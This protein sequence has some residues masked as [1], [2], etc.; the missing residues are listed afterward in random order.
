MREP[1]LFLACVIVTGQQVAPHGVI[2]AQIRVDLGDVVHALMASR[3]RFTS[4]P[5]R[6][7]SVSIIA[8]TKPIVFVQGNLPT[9]IHALPWL[10]PAAS[11][12]D[13]SMPTLT[14]IQLLSTNVCRT[15]LRSVEVNTS[16]QY[17]S[18]ANPDPAA[19]NGVDGE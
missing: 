11:C 2:S 8:A 6:Q 16:C 13:D 1:H 4:R 14:Q 12:R 15:L 9:D 10:C 5:V 7:V 18:A 17:A 3:V 19:V